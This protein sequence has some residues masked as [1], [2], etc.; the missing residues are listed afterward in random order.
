VVSFNDGGNRSDQRKS[1]ICHKSLTK[2]IN[3]LQQIYG[4]TSARR[5]PQNPFLQFIQ[6][7]G[8]NHR[9]PSYNS[10]KC[11]EK[12]TE[13]PLTIHTS[14][15]RQPQNPFLQ[16]TQVPGDNHRIPSYNSHKCPLYLFFAMK[17]IDQSVWINTVM[18]FNA[19]LNNMSVI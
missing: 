11:P 5:Q 18:V 15:R 7:P 4:H 8:D 6:V 3:D 1:L 12:T 17:T 16:F 19:T 13:S 10:Y 9:I 2:F 14:A